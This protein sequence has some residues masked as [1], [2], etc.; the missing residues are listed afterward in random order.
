MSNFAEESDYFD[1]YDGLKLFYRAWKPT[2]VKENYIFVGIHGACVHSSNMQN[3]GEF[4]A[5]KGFPVFVYDRRSFGHCDEKMRGYID[6]Y[7]TYVKDTISFIK[8]LKEKDKPKKIFLV[9]HSNGGTVSS[10]VAAENLDL[11]DSLVLSAPA[12][13]LKSKDLFSPLRKP[14]ALVLGTIF[15]KMKT[16]NFLKPEEL[17]R[18][19]E[20]ANIR[21][22]DPM[23]VSKITARWV[24]EMFSCQKQAINSIQ[25]VSIPTLFLIP[26]NDMEISSKFSLKLFD[27][28]KDKENM[29]LKY[30]KD[31]YHE[32]FND[33][34]ESRLIVFNDI[35][36]FLKLD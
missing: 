4:F 20:I 16:P 7:K 29:K 6:S 19:P 26:G 13:R 30:Y 22:E 9:G 3:L 2:K 8:F 24:R 28:L 23:Y 32:N 10:I 1:S 34:P 21:E 33:L 5:N 14:L 25:Q 35:S 27:K 18:D 15:P 17:A 36:E 11:V 31:N 12:Y